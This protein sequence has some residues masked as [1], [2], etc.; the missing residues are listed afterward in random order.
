[1]KSFT[2]TISW[3]S[4]DTVH[5]HTWLYLCQHKSLFW[6][7]FTSTLDICPADS[8]ATKLAMH[9]K[10]CRHSLTWNLL[11]RIFFSFTIV[12][13]PAL[14]LLLLSLMC[15]NILNVRPSSVCCR[16]GPNWFSAVNY[17]TWS[18]PLCCRSTWTSWYKQTALWKKKNNN[19]K[20]L[21]EEKKMP[22]AALICA[23]SLR[24]V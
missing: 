8:S 11:K 16:D 21:H 2:Q 6:R 9:M 15:R 22:S 18:L 14:C 24:D 7:C 17:D 20:W 10:P 3:C 23:G 19:S 5:T 4:Y 1:M 12:E 13:E